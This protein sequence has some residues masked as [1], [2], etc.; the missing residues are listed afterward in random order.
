M[1]FLLCILEELVSNI[2]ADPMI[3]HLD[4][5]IFKIPN[6]AQNGI[7]NM[8]RVFSGLNQRPHVTFNWISVEAQYFRGNVCGWIQVRD[9]LFFGA[10]LFTISHFSCVFIV[11]IKVNKH[12]I[13]PWTR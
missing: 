9:L 10:S 2:V 3:V 13:I 5:L 8:I 4:T 1:S 6:F 7:V 12:L 11:I